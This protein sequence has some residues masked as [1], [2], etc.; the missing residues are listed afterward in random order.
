MNQS[1]CLATWGSLHRPFDSIDGD[2]ARRRNLCVYGSRQRSKDVRPAPPISISSIAKSLRVRESTRN[3]LWI[4]PWCTISQQHQKCFTLLL[5]PLSLSLPSDF[6]VHIKLKIV[7]AQYSWEL[8]HLTLSH[9]Y[10]FSEANKLQI[11]FDSIHASVYFFFIILIPSF[12]TIYVH[13]ATFRLEMHSMCIRSKMTRF[14]SQSEFKWTSTCHSLLFSYS[15]KSR[16]E[17]SSRGSFPNLYTHIR[18]K[19]MCSHL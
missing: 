11:Y 1:R 14:H 10:L 8:V 16:T 4:R 6:V 3:H 12:S 19:E 9:R 18:S 13:E 15:M 2:E 17:F 5:V 7:C